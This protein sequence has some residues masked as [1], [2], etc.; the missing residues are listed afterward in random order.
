MTGLTPVK[1]EAI[2]DNTE[3]KRPRQ[4]HKLRLPQKKDLRS[5]PPVKCM[6]KLTATDEIS[7]PT[8]TVLC[9]SLPECLAGSRTVMALGTVASSIFLDNSGKTTT[10][11]IGTPQKYLWNSHTMIEVARPAAP[12]PIKR[13]GRRIRNGS[14]T[15]LELQYGACST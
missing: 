11:V 3:K 8:R 14:D 5:T 7:N 13:A 2:G 6:P 12:S 4:T 10:A 15:R 1:A 9:M